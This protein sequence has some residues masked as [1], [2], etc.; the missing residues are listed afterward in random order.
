MLTLRPATVEDAQALF[1]WRNDPA[2]RLSS[3]DTGELAFDHHLAWLTQTLADP[4]RRLLIAEELGRPVG[5]VR[6]DQGQD[7]VAE[8]SWTV[9]PHARGLGVAT[10]MVCQIAD[11]VAAV[12]PLR[13]EI[14]Q[15][16]AASAKVAQAAGMHLSRRDGEVLHFVRE[17]DA[18]N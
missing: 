17:R 14:K 13:A 10:R 4:A 1:D 16:N 3:H 8:L 2:T 11:Q 5:T 18:G 6:V 12:Q 9:A 15:D 7:G